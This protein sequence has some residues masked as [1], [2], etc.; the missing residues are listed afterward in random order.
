[1]IIAA[2][3]WCED[4][5]NI[6]NSAGTSSIARRST[7]CAGRSMGRRHGM[8]LSTA[9]HHETREWI[10]RNSPV[11]IGTVPISSAEKVNR[12]GRGSDHRSVHRDVVRAGRG[13]A[14]TTSPPR[15]RA[16][17]VHPMTRAG[18][19]GIVSRGDRSWQVVPGA[20]QGELLYTEFSASA[21]MRDACVRRW[22]SA[23]AEPQVA[24]ANATSVFL[25][26]L[27]DALE[28]PV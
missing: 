18:V 25:H 3:S 15:R 21:I 19:T 6:G 13:R 8:D 17:A 1:M 7:S 27:A 16:A 10:V 9:T 11:P 28:L 2:T 22:R 23:K 12:Q 14:S 4:Q 24:Q 26:A 20:S 5:R